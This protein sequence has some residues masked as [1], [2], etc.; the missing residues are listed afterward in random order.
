MARDVQVEYHQLTHAI[1]NSG[2]LK[3]RSLEPNPD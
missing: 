3:V 1:S 2:G